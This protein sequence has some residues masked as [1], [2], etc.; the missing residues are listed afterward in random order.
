MMATT[1]SLSTAAMKRRQR[2]AQQSP[3]FT[4]FRPRRFGEP[5]IGTPSPGLKETL[6][7]A[8]IDGARRKRQRLVLQKRRLLPQASTL[9]IEGEMNEDYQSARLVVEEELKR[10]GVAVHHCFDEEMEA[11]RAF[12]DGQGDH[13]MAEARKIQNEGSVDEN[14]STDWES[15]PPRDTCISEDDLFDLMQAVEDEMDRFDG[16]L[17][18]FCPFPLSNF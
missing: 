2:D 18:Y 17:L 11:Q 6:R 15:L 16:E 4:K 8:C 7:K 1:P 9:K 14:S 5:S 13:I 10:R 3:Y 12:L